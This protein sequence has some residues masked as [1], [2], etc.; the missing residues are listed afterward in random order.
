M[1]DRSA[2][3]AAVALSAD[4]SWSVARAASVAATGDTKAMNRTQQAVVTMT[5]G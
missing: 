2:G 1:Q 5:A 3:S 4:R